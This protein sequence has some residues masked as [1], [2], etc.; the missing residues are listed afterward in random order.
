[1]SQTENLMIDNAPYYRGKNIYTGGELIRKFLPDIQ[2]MFEQERVPYRMIWELLM[3]LKDLVYYGMQ[4]LEDN[5]LLEDEL[6]G[7]DSFDLF[8]EALTRCLEH[9]DAWLYDEDE[10][11]WHLE[12]LET[13]TSAMSRIGVED[14][15]AK[16][17]I[18]IRRLLDKRVLYDF[19][20][21]KRRRQKRCKEYARCMRWAGTA[22]KQ[23]GGCRRGCANEDDDSKALPSWHSTSRHFAGS[24]KF[25]LDGG[26]VALR[27]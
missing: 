2:A 11:L 25:P 4:C 24:G 14:F 12:S 20:G 17:T 5:T 26:K 6:S 1:M 13:T 9:K 10:V 3:E 21:Q 23:A 27:S 7:Y 19:G 8:D 15:C 16:S 22:W 18:T